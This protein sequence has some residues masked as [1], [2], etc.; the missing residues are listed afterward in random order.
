MSIIVET[1]QTEE[2]TRKIN[3]QK[4]NLEVYEIDGESENFIVKICA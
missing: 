1:V 2:S 3:L 4:D